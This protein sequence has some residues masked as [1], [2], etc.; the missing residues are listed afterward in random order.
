MTKQDE[1][2]LCS[3]CM[4]CVR[5]CPKE[6]IRV[7]LSNKRKIVQMID[8]QKCVQCHQCTR[9]CPH[10]GLASLHKPL[11][12]YTGVAKKRKTLYNASSGGIASLLYEYC[13]KHHIPCVGVT[14][15]SELALKYRFLENNRD[16]HYAQGSKYA[17]SNM[18]I[19]YEKVATALSEKR[20][21]FI[22]LP[23]H[24]EALKKYLEVKNANIQ[25]LMTVDIVCH[26][27]TPPL[28]FQEHIEF[29][30]KRYGRINDIRFREKKNQYGVTLFDDKEKIIA[31][32][33]RFEDEYMLLFQNGYYLDAC[34]RCRFAKG[35]RVGDLTIKDC[36]G[37]GFKSL[38]GIYPIQSSVL[39]NTLLGES[40]LDQLRE[41][42]VIYTYKC[43]TEMIIGADQMLQ[44]PSP[45]PTAYSFFYLLE[46][47]V[48]YRMAAQI[49]YGYQ[50]L[51]STR[52]KR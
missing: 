15:N 50:R 10:E 24:V 19:I 39:V 26:G 42:K 46:S 32:R 6:C 4:A 29:L 48:G 37:S 44:M 43:S 5:I 47:L 18:G 1:K 14:F 20:V 34:Y 8:M 11:A 28:F 16:I 38:S 51:V 30:R 52:E 35:D 36:T 3:G 33:Y 22:G 21:L 12:G 40:I 13:L 9:V 31:K 49:I 45:M 2:K 17:F 7:D 27:V 41:E 25:N 23:C